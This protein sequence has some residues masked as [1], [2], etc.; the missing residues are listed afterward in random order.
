MH[1]VHKLYACSAYKSGVSVSKSFAIV[2]L[3]D[4][5]DCLDLLDY[6]ALILIKTE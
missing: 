2:A 5:L 1:C 3:L 4:L 6:G